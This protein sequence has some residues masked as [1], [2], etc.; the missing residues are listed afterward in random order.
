VRLECRGYA[1]RIH[2]GLGAEFAFTNW[3]SV[4]V[5]ANYYNFDDESIEFTRDSCGQ[6]GC[7]PFDKRIEEEKFMSKLA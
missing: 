2:S 7:D 4:F 5:E 6:I 3:A 1:H